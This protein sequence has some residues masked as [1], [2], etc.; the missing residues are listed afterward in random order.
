MELN[1]FLFIYFIFNLLINKVNEVPNFKN[2]I[3]N[4][5]F[6]IIGRQRYIQK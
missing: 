2:I 1:N 3:S 6:N 5:L 4:D